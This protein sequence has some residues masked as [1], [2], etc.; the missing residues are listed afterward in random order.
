MVVP[1][2]QAFARVSFSV[3]FWLMVLAYGVMAADGAARLLLG[4]A[5]RVALLAA[6]PSRRWRACSPR[7]GGTGCRCSRNMPPIATASGPKAGTHVLLAFGSLLAATAVGLP[8]GVACAR[9]ARLRAATLPVLN[10]VQTVP[11]IAMYG[12]MMVP[13]GLL[14]TAVP[15]LGTLGIR[16]IGV[17]PAAAALFL[18]ALLPVVANTAVGLDGVP[19]AAV[20]AARGMGMGNGPPV[21]V[22]RVAA[23]PR[24]SSSPAS[25]SCSCRTSAS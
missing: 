5:A 19:R 13:L 9:S 2:K 20:E 1:P 6:P 18:Y 16:G 11:S 22:G 24:P 17:A 21:V 15:L 4:P 3:G 12:L 14:A 10:V 23:G 7:A 8:L 25:A